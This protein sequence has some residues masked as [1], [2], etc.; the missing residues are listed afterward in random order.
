MSSTQ[1]LTR[2]SIELQRPAENEIRAQAQ[3]PEWQAATQ[4]ADPDNVIEASRIADASVP[5]GGYGWVIVASCSTLC[6]WFGECLF[7]LVRMSLS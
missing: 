2:E 6:F 3:E 4:P 1:T 7:P 5:D